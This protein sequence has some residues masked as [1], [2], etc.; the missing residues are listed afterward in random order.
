MCISIIYIY[1]HIYIYIY[2][3]DIIHNDTYIHRYKRKIETE[4]VAKCILL[5]L[6]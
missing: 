3:Y 1:T 4:E 5:M 6:I 2:T